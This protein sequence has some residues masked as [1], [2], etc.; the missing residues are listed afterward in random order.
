MQ[1]LT[2]TKFSQTPLGQQE[3]IG[4]ATEQAELD[5]PFRPLDKENDNIDRLIVCI[6]FILPYCSVCILLL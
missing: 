3:I 2:N 6:R 4:I 5:A 1:Y